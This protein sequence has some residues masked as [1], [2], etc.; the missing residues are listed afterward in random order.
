MLRGDQTLFATSL[1]SARKWLDE[2]VDPD[3]AATQRISK[4]L[5]RLAG[6]DIE[7][8]M[9]DISGSLARLREIQSRQPD[10]E[11]SPAAEQGQTE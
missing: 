5:D 1:S 10:P 3:H 7:R 2:Y 9:P 8:P 11:P 6:L 4:D